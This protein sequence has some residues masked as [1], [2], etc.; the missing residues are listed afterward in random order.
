MIVVVLAATLHCTQV[1]LPPVTDVEDC[2]RVTHSV[3]FPRCDFGNPAL[4]KQVNDYVEDHVRDEGEYGDEP[5]NDCPSA[6]MQ[7]FD[8]SLDAWCEKPF[9][10]ADIVSYVCRTV[11]SRPRPGGTPFSINLRL[12]N[13]IQEIELRDLLVNEAAEARIWKLVAK[14]VKRQLLESDPDRLPDDDQ[15]LLEGVK[16]GAMS[17]TRKGLMF[18]YDHLSFG[19][20]VADSTIPYAK[21]R[22]ILEPEFIPKRKP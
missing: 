15:E 8:G 16:H 22:G 12:R 6:E 1:Q 18:S 19:W 9:R 17:L 13:P 21:L 3:E 10:V 11:W 7:E 20:T 5:Q 2:Q 4:T 14:D